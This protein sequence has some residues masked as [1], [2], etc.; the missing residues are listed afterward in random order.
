MDEHTKAQLRASLIGAIDIWFAAEQEQNSAL[1]WVG[2]STVAYIADAAMSVI[3]AL[4][5]TQKYLE[6]EQISL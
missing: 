2:P 3:Y 1:P 5:D 6:D 4:Q